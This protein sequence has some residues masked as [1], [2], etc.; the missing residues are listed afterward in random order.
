[1][2]K[3]QVPIVH[4]LAALA[5]LGQYHQDVSFL[6]TTA[7]NAIHWLTGEYEMK[8]ALVQELHK[9]LT[10]ATERVRRH[11]QDGEEV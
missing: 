10:E 9:Q 2:A 3:K 11:Y 8:P 4:P 5:S 7:H 1:M 6:M